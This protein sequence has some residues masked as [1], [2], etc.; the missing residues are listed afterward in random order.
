M[1]DDIPK[2]LQDFDFNEIG[3]NQQNIWRLRDELNATR[4]WLRENTVTP[5]GGPSFEEEPA[6]HGY[7]NA[8]R[9][10]KAKGLVPGGTLRPGVTVTKN[11]RYSMAGKGFVKASEAFL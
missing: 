5:E 4:R 11:G 8:M 7:V 9:D 10:A 3:N 6:M 2:E 1:N